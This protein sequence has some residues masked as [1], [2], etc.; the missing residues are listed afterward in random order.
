MLGTVSKGK[1]FGGIY[2]PQEEIRN[3]LFPYSCSLFRQPVLLEGLIEALQFSLIK[4]ESE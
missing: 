2:F 3:E 1:K 4:P